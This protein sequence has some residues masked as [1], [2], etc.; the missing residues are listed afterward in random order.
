MLSLTR[1]T[2]YALVALA[3]LGRRYQQNEKPAS[4]RVIADAYKLP[5]PLLMNVL[6]ELSSTD[7]LV[8]TRGATG[9]YKL[10]REPESIS[11]HDVVIA[12]EGPLRVALCADKEN[13]GHHCSIEMDC[14]IKT[15]IR[16]L[17]QRVTQ[18]FK[19][20]S[21][22]ELIAESDFAGQTEPCQ[23]GCSSTEKLAKIAIENKTES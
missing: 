13:N 7:I 2:D 11:L 8:S 18:V 3:D 6:K 22:A 21:L 10:A 23:C 12:I 4:A 1:K 19:D 17:H 20:M 15:P 5:L 16:T 9:G 14:P